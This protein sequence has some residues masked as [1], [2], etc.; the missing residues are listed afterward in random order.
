MALRTIFYLCALRVGV[1]L[2]MSSVVCKYCPSVSVEL[3]CTQP[4]PT[5]QTLPTPL[6]AC[7]PPRST[8][9][10]PLPPRP[11]ISSSLL[12]L[13]EPHI[14]P[15]TPR[16]LSLHERYKATWLKWKILWLGVARYWLYQTHADTQMYFYTLTTTHR[17]SASSTEYAHYITK[18]LNY[19]RHT[20][21]KVHTHTRGDTHMLIHTHTH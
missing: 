11:F 6:P 12:C 10:S 21:S 13:S 15:H 18:V 3:L 14:P 7:S 9:P 1:C 16:S 4:Q 5:Q 20:R 19:Y 8:S 17:V 2:C